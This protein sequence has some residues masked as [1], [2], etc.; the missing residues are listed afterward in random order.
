LVRKDLPKG[1]GC[2]LKAGSVNRNE[3]VTFRLNLRGGYGVAIAFVTEQKK[4]EA[5]MTGNKGVAR[6]QF[7]KLAGMAAAAG[8]SDA[9]AAPTDTKVHLVVPANTPPFNAAPVVWALE[10][11]KAAL[12]LKKITFETS[13]KP[14]D[15][16]NIILADHQDFPA[17]P[18]PDNPESLQISPGPGGKAELWITGGG[19]VGIAYALTELADRVTY[20]APGTTGLNIKT[21]IH[22]TPANVIR[23]IDRLFVSEIEDKPWFYDRDM[24]TGYL[25]TLATSRFNRFTLAFG[26]GYDAPVD[27]SENYFHFTYPY[28]LNVPGYDVRVLDVSDEERARNLD[29]LK[30]IAR[31]TA[32]RGIAFQLGLWSHAYDGVNSPRQEHHFT[33]LTPQNHSAYVRDAMTLLLKEVPEI[34][35]VTMRIHGESGIPEGSWDFWTTLFSAFKTAGRT[36]SIDMHAKGMTQNMIDIAKGTGMPFMISPKF[37]AEHMGLGYHQA[38]IRPAEFN[39]PAKPGDTDTMTISSNQR[40]FTRYGYSDLFVEG[41]PYGVLHR[42]WP[43]SQRH[44]MWGDPALV[45]GFSRA[46]SFC[47]SL[48]LDVMEPLTFKGREGTGRHDGRSA[49]ADKSLA[50]GT[51][52]WAK[53]AYYYRV[54]GRLL[55]NP[56]TNAEVWRRYLMATFGPAA[57]AMEAAMASASQVQPIFF[58]THCPSASNRGYWPEVYTDM[59]IIPDDKNAPYKEMTAPYIVSRVSPLD[60]QLFASIED[61]VGDLYAGKPIS[62]YSPTETIGWLD[63]V[64]TA[65]DAALTKAK[66]QVP[67]SAAVEFHRWEEDIRITIGQGRFFAGKLRTALYHEIWK[68]GG[69][70]TAATLAMDT[71]MKARDAWAQMA[72]RAAKVYVADITYGEIPLRHGSWQ[73]RLPAI[74]HNIANLKDALAQPRPAPADPKGAAALAFAKSRPV[75]PVIAAQHKPPQTFTPGAA[76]TVHLASAP[77]KAA[78]LWYRH[79]YQ[80]ERWA[81]VA[82]TGDSNNWQA[83]IPADYTQSPYPLQYYFELDTGAPLTAMVPGFNAT[84]SNTPYYSVYK[85]A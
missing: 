57:A 79:V 19:P 65:A 74:D 50:L 42:L 18:T 83:A 60:P 46:A 76:L 11:L 77:A 73:D 12:T 62:R 56:D 64:T 26:L 16:F 22:E 32:R 63:D 68:R 1:L 31:E 49:Y 4:A 40:R 43:G 15:G 36:I 67:P 25:D 23:G 48:G 59:A 21:A 29:T 34:S 33:G 70:E 38:D 41:R 51:G 9:K 71:Q 10:K 75:R 24:W 35:G 37:S 44:L 53:F 39:R 7:I 61:H 13:T 69:P 80:G 58:S 85:R 27:I 14:G 84:R 30:F 47:G 20:A 55:Y 82:M 54:W 3:K 66:A 72:D 17:R 78:K 6:R 5:E 52:E 45:S 8:A 81:S 28:L 2:R